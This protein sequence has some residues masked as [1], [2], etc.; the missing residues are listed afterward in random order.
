MQ[1]AEQAL[2]TWQNKR[3]TQYTYVLEPTGAGNPGRALRIEV[4]DEEVLAAV[5][6]DG[7]EATADRLSMTGLLES[8]LDAS[9]RDSFNATY[10][11]ELGY[12]KSFFYAPGPDDEPAGYGFEV[13]CFEPRLDAGACADQFRLSAAP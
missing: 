1:K 2:T 8:A 6:R 10:D 9:E 3:P 4:Q 7:R 13:P 11:A 12:V 5:E